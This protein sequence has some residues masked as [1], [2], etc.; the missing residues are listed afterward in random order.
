MRLIMECGGDLLALMDGERVVCRV[1]TD[2]TDLGWQEHLESFI[3]RH[4]GMLGV[5]DYLFSLC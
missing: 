3:A 2:K 1:R 4:G 5:R